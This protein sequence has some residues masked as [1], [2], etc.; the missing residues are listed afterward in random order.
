MM[1]GPHGLPRL[2]ADL[3]TVTEEAHT[4]EFDPLEI[5]RDIHGGRGVKPLSAAHRG[6]DH[7]TRN[8]ERLTREQADVLSELA[9]ELWAGAAAAN[10]QAMTN[11]FNGYLSQVSKA[12]LTTRNC[13][14]AMVQTFLSTQFDVVQ[15]EIVEKNRLAA[16]LVDGN[17]LAE[18]HESARLE[19]EYQQYVVKNQQALQRYS[20]SALNIAQSLPALPEL[21]LL[22][23]KPL[24]NSH[25]PEISQE[26]G[27]RQQL[28][29]WWDTF[30]DAAQGFAGLVVESFLDWWH[31]LCASLSEMLRS[32]PPEPASFELSELGSAS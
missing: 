3:A 8:L 1:P 11:E 14:N 9:L 17:P 10:M 29:Q 13:C 5:S 22:E 6:W 4:F 26:P 23:A 15:P 27:I 16:A 32:A 24:P 18:A 2:V 7:L 30:T 31:R 12:A 21:P 20:R 25:Q 19:G 28:S